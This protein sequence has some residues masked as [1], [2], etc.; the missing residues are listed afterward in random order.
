MKAYYLIVSLLATIGISL[1]IP[2]YPV[3]IGMIG[4]GIAVGY[5]NEVDSYNKKN[6]DKK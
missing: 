3:L 2:N 6:T 1:L 4:F 5:R